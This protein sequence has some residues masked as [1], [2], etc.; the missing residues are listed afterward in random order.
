MAI[1]NK[2]PRWKP[3]LFPV[4][5]RELDFVLSQDN[6]PRIDIDG[7]MTNRCLIS[8]IDATKPECA[9]DY[10]GLTKSLPIENTAIAEEIELKNIGFTGVD[11][12]FVSYDK[13]MSVEEFAHVMVDSTYIVPSGDTRLTLFPMR[14]NTGYFTYDYSYNQEG[15]YEFHGG[16][17]QGFYKLY[18]QN[19]SV[20]P[21]YIQDA[22]NLEFVIR[23]RKDYEVSGHTF[24]DEHP[25]NKGIFFYIGTRSEN[26]FGRFYGEDITKYPKRDIETQERSGYT[27]GEYELMTSEDHPLDTD[28]FYELITDN[29]FLIFNR[30]KDG[31]TT[32]TWK[33]ED[34]LRLIEWEKSRHVNLFPLMNRTKDGYTVDNIDK[35][36]DS[37]TGQS[38]YYSIM[39]DVKD[40]AFAVKYNDDGSIGY[41]YLIR[42][43]SNPSG[44]SVAEECTYSGLVE[45]NEWTTINVMCKIVDGNPDKCGISVGNRKMRIFIYVNGYLKL[46]SKELPEFRFRALNDYPDKQEGVPFNLSLGGGTPGLAESAWL[47]NYGEPFKRILPIEQ[48]FSGSF[49]GDIRSF[50]FYDCQ[51]QYNEIK[52]NFLYEDGLTKNMKLQWEL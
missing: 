41:K 46:V 14:S 23:P 7:N 5:D 52:N 3:I 12:G 17:M 36:Y 8:Y 9:P 47:D 18:K 49:I 29:K 11:N 15:Y 51:L 28:K 16:F 25:D 38:Q 2:Y 40:N 39:N 43:C 13:D 45:D 35:Y 26:K 19:Y 27:P 33:D 20:L 22:W 4:R 6:S 50:K 24:N 31:Y 44:W 30:T 21:E 42:D 34:L 10:S 1:L 32:D 48:N 37:I